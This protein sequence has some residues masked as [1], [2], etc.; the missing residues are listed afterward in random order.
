[1]HSNVPA[2][3]FRVAVVMLRHTPPSLALAL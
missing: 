3:S 1:V 2:A